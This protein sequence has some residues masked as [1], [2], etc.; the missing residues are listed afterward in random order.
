MPKQATLG[1]ISYQLRELREVVQR[2]NYD[3]C[4]TYIQRTRAAGR[5]GTL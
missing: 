3:T 4:C 2:F 1:L 5:A